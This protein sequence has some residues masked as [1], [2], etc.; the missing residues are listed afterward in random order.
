MTT[1][2][3]AIL[4]FLLLITVH[5]FGHFIA[6]KAV[7]IRVL[8]F[9]IGM[10]PAIFKRKKGETLYSLRVLPVGG[11]CKMEGEDEESDD[12]A[13]FGNKSPWKR[14]IV[15]VAG[16][17]MN[18]F[19][20]FLI[21]VVIMSAISQ[22]YVPV[23]EKVIEDYPA[24]A[25]GLMEGDRITKINGTRINIYQDLHFEMSRNAGSEIKIEFVRNGE[26][27][28]TILT[29]LK[30]ENGEYKIGFYPSVAKH[31]FIGRLR[32][33]FYY[34]LYTSKIIIVS[35]IDLLRGGYSVKEVSGPVGIVQH[36]GEAAKTSI[37]DLLNLT[38]FITINLGVFNLLP[39]PALDGGRILFVLVEAVRR[40]KIP[41]EKEGLVHFVGFA[42]LILLMIFA[43][44]NDISRIFGG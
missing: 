5:E 15:L 36:I 23:I 16:A 40:K 21:F 39:I 13:A 35:L 42:L 25:A 33:S 12:E 30:D 43:T 20:G 7:G 14:L 41:A 37:W 24:E 31:G 26:K 11:F 10:G 27:K 1:A 22:T 34:T 9:A 29:P 3:S 38:A 8:E 17:F 32:N 28:S 19:T 44:T 4:I 2:I 6:A 18:I